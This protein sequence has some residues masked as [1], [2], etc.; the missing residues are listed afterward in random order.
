MPK[1]LLAV[2]PSIRLLCGV[3]AGKHM[4][5]SYKLIKGRTKLIKPSGWTSKVMYM[6]T[7]FGSRKTN[8]IKANV[9]QRDILL[10][11]VR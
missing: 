3:V 6:I 11:T 9:W 5:L 2:R 10:L 7:L 1:A 4:K 8:H